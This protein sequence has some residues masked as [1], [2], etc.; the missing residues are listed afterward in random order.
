VELLASATATN[1]PPSGASAGLDTNALR[2]DGR[3]PE[4]VSI[5]VVSTAGSGTMTMDLRIWGYDGVS[6]TWVPLGTGGD[7]T[8]VGSKGSLNE[9]TQ[10]GV[11]E[12]NALQHAE[13]L[14][15]PCHLRS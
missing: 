3:V 10:I 11:T 5:V 4:E 2:L 8:G 13:P 15:N 14:R 6:T 9:G 1:S 7:G 12:A